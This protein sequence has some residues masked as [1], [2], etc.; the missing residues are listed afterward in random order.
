MA[1]ISELVQS[2]FA[3]FNSIIKSEPLVDC[4]E[5]PL[6]DWRDELGRLRVWAA[7]IGAHQTR[8]SSLDYRLRDASHIRSQIVVLL[9]QIQELLTDLED[10]LQEQ[11]DEASQSHD[12][13]Y[14]EGV[15][16]SE[17]F[18]SEIQEIHEALVDTIGQ[19]YQ[20]SMLIRKPSQHDRLVGTDK[21]DSEPFQFW[22]K[23][24]TSEKYPNADPLAIDRISSAMARQRAVLK[25]R[26]R[27]HEKLSKGIDPDNDGKSTVLSETVVTHLFKEIP[28]QTSDLISEAGVSETSYGGTLLEGTGSDAPKIPPRPKGADNGPF[29][30]PYC[31]YIITAKDKKSWA[32]HIFRDLMPYVCIFPECPTPNKLYESRRQWHHHIKQAHITPVT[33]KNT[34]DC[35]ICRRD[36]LPISNFQKH[37]G[38]HLEELALFLLPRTGSDEDENGGTNEEKEGNDSDE[39]ASDASHNGDLTEN[40]TILLDAIIDSEPGRERPENGANDQIDHAD[41]E[42]GDLNILLAAHTRNDQQTPSRFIST[43]ATESDLS[44]NSLPGQGRSIDIDDMEQTSDIEIQLQEIERLKKDLKRHYDKYKTVSENKVTREETEKW[45]NDISELLQHAKRVE[46]HAMGSEKRAEQDRKPS[47]WKL[48]ELKEGEENVAEEDGLNNDLDQ[49][50]IPEI[51]LKTARQERERIRERIVEMEKKD[52]EILLRNAAVDEWK[53][54]EAKSTSQKDLEFRNKLRDEFCYDEEEIEK[55]LSK[56]SRDEGKK[57]N[58]DDKGKGKEDIPDTK[59]TWIKN[60]SDYI[61]I[62]RWLSEDFQEE[63]FAYTRRIREGK[64]ISQPSLHKEDDIEKDKMPFVSKKK[65][66]ELVDVR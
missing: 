48:K 5:V 46:Q 38:Q 34:Y 58:E 14:I 19:L 41:D 4:T 27:H 23:S 10:V 31:F 2:C 53:M 21:A 65:P 20:M 8:Q 52:R 42:V 36:Y 24:H 32:R 15:S 49:E 6:Q 25:Y 45:E 37:V 47:E 12:S 44:R 7:N 28:S 40:I 22:A 18:T 26:E 54:E 56:K 33:Q 55:I 59:N 61:I 17:T 39:D 60:D 29:E 43:D 62:K 50:M 66:D 35:S 3:Q 64:A 9:G 16:D 63:L 11:N 57:A 30:C 51:D 13:E 1:T